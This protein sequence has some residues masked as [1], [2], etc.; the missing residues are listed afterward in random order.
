MA[1]DK[2][3]HFIVEKPPDIESHSSD[4][5]RNGNE[6][7]GGSWSHTTPRSRVYAQEQAAKK[8]RVALKMTSVKSQL[9]ALTATINELFDSGEIS[10]SPEHDLSGLQLEE[11]TLTVQVNAKGEI[12]ILGSGGE[13]G[14]SGGIHL[15]FVKP[16][17]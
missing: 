4:D 2:L 1:K 5:G 14:G 9:K 6:D 11:V 16:R 7:I 8:Q 15:K 17:K 12:G 10:T 3:V 13:I